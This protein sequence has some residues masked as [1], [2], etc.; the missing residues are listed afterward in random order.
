[1]RG[2]R[3]LFGL[4]VAMALSGGARA[5]EMIEIPTTAPPPP[6]CCVAVAS[7]AAREPGSLLLQIDAGPTYR[8]AFGEDFAAAAVELEV[9]GQT[10]SWGVS[11]RMRGDFGATRVGLPYQFFTFGPTFWRRMTP[12]LRLGVGAT[13]GVFVYERASASQAFDPTVWA[14]TIGVDLDVTVDLVRTRRDGAL[15][16][17]GRVSYDYIDNTSDNFATGSSVGFT[18]ALGYRY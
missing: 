12:R 1:M 11:G 5:Q 14:F 8:H 15:F 16:L 7:P 6:P 4:V 3:P 17:L 9:G 18:V 10:P 13:F 2:L